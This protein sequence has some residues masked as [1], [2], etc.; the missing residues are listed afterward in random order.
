MRQLP[1]DMVRPGMVI[2]RTVLNSRGDVLLRSGTILNER[3]LEMLRQRGYPAVLIADPDTDD[4]ELSDVLSERVRAAV[5][6]SV[7]ELYVGTA[8]DK[9]ERAIAESLRRLRQSVVEMVEEVMEGSAL[10]ALQAMR[11]RDSY[12]FEHAIDGTIVALLLARKLGYD[13]PALQRLASGCL[14]RDIGMARIAAEVL[15]QPGPLEP[16]GWTVVRQ[17]T[18]ASYA[19][20]RKVRPGAV[21]PNAIALQHH[22][23]QD[24]FG[25]PQGLR[26]TNRISREA[27]G[28]GRIILD[29]EIAAVADVYDA[30]GADRPHRRALPPDRIVV[31]LQ[32][33]AGSHLNRALVAQLLMILPVF[34]VGTEVLLRTGR[35]QGYRGM[36]VAVDPADLAHPIVRVLSDRDGR[37]VPP[38]EVDLRA[39]RSVLASVSLGD[40]LAE[41]A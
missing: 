3:Y 18:L 35:Y 26:G 20:L 36:V 10:V 9:D 24:G 1:I 19:I 40:R 30:L 13:K 6:Q 23:R 14:T 7:C 27:A 41:T 21:I 34:P 16:D 12:F 15:D 25:Y 28:Q 11:A 38:F 33:L 37:R 8:A 39:E 4:V 17:H 32:R 2:G 5:T 31:E 29:A 22:E